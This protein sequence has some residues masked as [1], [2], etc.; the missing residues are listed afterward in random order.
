MHGDHLFGLPGLLC[1]RSA[2]GAVTPLIIYGPIGT[3]Q[4]VETAL[5]VSKS[6]LSYDLSFIG[7]EEGIV[8]QDDSFL[9]EAIELDHVMP[10]FAFKI[11]EAD[12]PGSLKVEE[13]VK[14][15]IKPGPIFQKLKNGDEVLLEDGR[16]INGQ[17]YITDKKKGR[18]IVIAGDTRPLQK[19]KDFAKE[20][21]LLIH[22]GTFLAEKKEHA[23]QF[24]HSTIAD[25]AVLAKEA[26]VKKLIINHISS[27][28]AG[29]EELLEEEAKTI[30]NDSLIAFDFMVYKLMNNA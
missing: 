1:S 21:D 18:K 26:N 23:N 25:V 16:K 11:T 10:S 3:E 22:E 17:Q 30:F 6:Y 27:R 20:V 19:M 24:G 2:Q 7:V 4:F 13:L 29:D 14:L 8:Y 9:I 12:K 5:K 28:Y 15:G